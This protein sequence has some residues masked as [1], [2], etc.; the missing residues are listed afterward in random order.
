M[1]KTKTLCHKTKEPACLHAWTH[2][3]ISQLPL[4]IQGEHP[5]KTQRS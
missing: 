1:D 3:A 2:L 5:E 4:P